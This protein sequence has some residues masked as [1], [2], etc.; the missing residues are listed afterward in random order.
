LKTSVVIVTWNS[1]SDIQDC[2]DSIPSSDSLEVIVVDNYSTDSTTAI[3]RTYPGIKFIRNSSNRG[4]AHANN[5]GIRE[6]SGEYVLLLN[7]DTRL[8][9][10]SLDLLIDFLDRTPEAGAVAPRLIYPDGRTQYSIRS[11][12]TPSTVL[13]EVLGL[14]RLL[15]RHRRIGK[16]RMMW[17][18]YDILSEVEQ[19]M[20]S[21]L[22]IRRSI[23][24]ELHGLDEVLPIFF[25][26]VDLSY[27][28]RRAGW[29]T[30]YLPAACVVH[31][32]GASTGQVRTRMIRE[33]HRSMF[34]Y[35]R[36]HAQGRLFWL[37]AIF[38]LPLLE[39]S[40]LLRVL[41]HRLSSRRKDQ[42]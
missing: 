2:L 7:P 16:W 13:W 40:A 18:D 22:L 31:K 41:A 38:L 35:L 26:D 36:K 42:T 20:A 30:W 17:F 14:A 12:P 33:N 1:A 15:P 5:Q 25:N 10:G 27:R 4:Y 39:I 28:M 37:K 19:P 9:S 11:F 21:C 3:L 34:R 24:E 8:L 32:R 23:L 29:K 6:A